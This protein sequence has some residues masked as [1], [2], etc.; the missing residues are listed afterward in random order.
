MI[1][2]ACPSC[3]IHLRVEGNVA[4]CAACAEQYPTIEGIGRYLSAERAANF[5]DFLHDYTT[6]RLAEGRASDDPTYFR[7]LPEP[8][9][10]GPMEW[11]WQLRRHSW[12]TIRRQ[13]I[14]PAPPVL[15]VVDIGAGVGWLSNRL[16]ELGHIAHAV[17]LTVDAH[18]GLGAAHHFATE[19]VRSQAEMDALPIATGSVDVVFYNASLHYSCDYSRTLSEAL[20]VLKPAGR[21]VVMDS[22]IYHHRSSGEAMIAE[23]HAD[24]EA[25][26]GS[27]SDSVPSIGYLTADMLTELGAELGLRWSRHRTWYGWKWAWKPWRARLRRK[28]EPSRFTV[29]VGQRRR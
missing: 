14:S 5:A 4:T 19:F 13:I 3:H 7:R 9:P 16:T 11:Q 12:Q 20:R 17:D 22:P 2:L 24:F 23:R 18:D 28:R 8:T 10:G 25:R 6:V 15:S 21:I 27:R 26:F 1:V 29:L